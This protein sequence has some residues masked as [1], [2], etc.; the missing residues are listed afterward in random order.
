M[1]ETPHAV[2]DVHELVAILNIVGITYYA[3]SAERDEEFDDGDDAEKSGGQEWGLRIRHNENEYG[4]RLRLEITLAIGRVVVDA[5]M[6]YE[7]AEP[8]ELSQ[9]IAYEFANEVAIMALLPYMR[10]AVASATQRVFGEAMLLPILP[11]GAISFQPAADS[12]A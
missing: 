12:D 5:A 8:F 11:R 10:E 6:E 4:A 1:S 3:V 2:S 7:A 9:E